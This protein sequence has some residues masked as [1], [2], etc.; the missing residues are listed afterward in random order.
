MGDDQVGMESVLPTGTVTFLFT[1]IEGST[2]L[3]D[4]LG[5][6]RYGSLLAEHHRVCRQ[7]WIANGG[8]EFGTAGDAF[9]VVFVRP[10]DALRAAAAAQEALSAFG[11]PVRMGV[12]T[13]E[14]DVGETGYVGLE[15]HRAARIAAA[16]HGGQVVV[17]ASTA[18]LVDVPLLDLGEHRFKDLRASERMFQFGDGEFPRLKSL[19]RSNLPVPAT[20][21]LGREKELA[22]VVSMLMKPGARLVSLTGPG[23][24]GK[25]RLGLQAAA[26]ASDGFPDG[27][28]WVPL[29]PLR[30]PRRISSEV[31]SALGVREL[32]GG[33]ALDD[34]RQGLAEKR[35][36]V[37]LDNAE[38]LLPQAASLVGDFVSACPTVTVAVTSRERLRVPGEQVF[39]V[40]PMTET[41]AAAL[42][43]SRAADVGVKLEDSDVPVS[44]CAKLDNLPLALELAAA[45]TTVFGPAQLLERLSTRLDLLTGA[46][47]VD[48]R[49]ETLRA[50]IDWSHDLLDSDER[51]LFRRMSVFAGGCSYDSA[52]Q[53]AGADPDSLQSLLDKSLIRRR[54]SLSG[55]RFSMLETIREHAA[56]QLAAAGETGEL[57]LLHLDHYAA[58]AADCYDE[59]RSGRDD[60]ER[61]HDERDNLR[62]ALDLAIETN[63]EVALALA[64]HLMPDWAHGE[65]REGREKLEAALARAPC[66]PTLRRAEA[67]WA[68]ANLASYQPDVTAQETHSLAALEM[69]RTLGDRVGEGRALRLVGWLAFHRGQL[70]Q[71]KDLF[72]QAADALNTPRSQGPYRDAL[73]DISTILFDRGERAEALGRQRELVATEPLEG[74]ELVWRLWRLGELEREAGEIQAAQRSLE[75]AVDLARR[76]ALNRRVLG[77]CLQALGRVLRDSASDDALAAFSESLQLCLEMDNSDGIG[78]CLEGAAPIFTADN[79]AHATSLLAT[80]AAIRTQIGDVRSP[81]EKAEADAAESQCRQALTPESFAEAWERGASLDAHAAA[82]FA[83]QVWEQTTQGER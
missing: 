27:V 72:E 42:F 52:E 17:S 29:A 75:E 21:F 35:S 56:E 65:F 38:H 82:T 47:G 45:R 23:G 3:L 36:L 55:P 25:T 31:V 69:F 76:T 33:S 7:S 26:D 28:F 37:F 4:E 6:E 8:V 78:Y 54:E 53:V 16:G 67:F 46:R 14:V 68:A 60:L 10:L 81:H 18:A 62:L 51:R 44:L 34:L 32:A 58:I 12:H 9:F 74:T 83:L 70:D 64:T 59:T 63:P 15:V 71:A 5:A 24:A 11:L 30:D 22:E 77:I 39:A 49:Q 80:A 66:E 41:D 2:R 1:D 19:Y 20:S 73:Q 57:Q 13:G 61:F 43:R 40:P 50:T 79:P 48:Q